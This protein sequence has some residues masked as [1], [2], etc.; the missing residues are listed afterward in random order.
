MRLEPELW[1]ALE[2]ICRRENTTLADLVKH[3]EHVGHPGGRTSAVRVHVLNYFR[4]AAHGRHVNGDGLTRR[5][6]GGWG[7]V[8]ASR[9][10]NAA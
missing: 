5:A 8:Q 4:A 3:I 9:E 7:E 10:A 6:D 2:E 1:D